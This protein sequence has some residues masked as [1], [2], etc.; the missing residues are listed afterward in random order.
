MS[1]GS[2]GWG[3]PYPYRV[4]RLVRARGRR[5]IGIFVRARNVPGV[6]AGIAETLAELGINI[7]SIH[8]SPVLGREELSTGFMVLDLTGLTLNPDDVAEPLARVEGVLE[9]SVVEPGSSGTFLD[10]HHFPLRGEAG[11]RYLP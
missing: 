7:K 5:L 8:F 2:G 6:V 3:E 10:S 4:D 9:I 1:R 11:E